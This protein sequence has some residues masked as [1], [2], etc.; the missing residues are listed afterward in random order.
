ML[1]A[2]PFETVA[3]QGQFVLRQRTR[4]VATASCWAA[5]SMFQQRRAHIRRH[6]LLQVPTPHIDSRSAASA[7]AMRPSRRKPSAAARVTCMRHLPRRD[8]S[9]KC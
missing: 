3:R 6:L 5:D 1:P 8:R 7:S 4:R 9:E 2:R